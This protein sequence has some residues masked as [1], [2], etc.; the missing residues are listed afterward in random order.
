MRGRPATFD[1]RRR[2]TR[3]A[4]GRARDAAL[5]VVDEMSAKGLDQS[6]IAWALF[7]TAGLAIHPQRA[8]TASA[9]LAADERAAGGLSESR[10]S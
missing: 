1:R 8:S 7:A 9:C 3:A 10:L 2:T 4:V 5:Q 6:A